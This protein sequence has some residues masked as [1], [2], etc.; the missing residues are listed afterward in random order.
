[1][2]LDTKIL[3]ELKL[4]YDNMW[5]NLV[6]ALVHT[7]TTPEQRDVL[8]DQFKDISDMYWKAE[9]EYKKMLKQGER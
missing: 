6:Y 1:M 2:T 8:T 5:Q 9:R 4:R 7:E 3:D